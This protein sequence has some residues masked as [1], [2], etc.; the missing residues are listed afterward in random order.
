M[1]IPAAFIGPPRSKT[2]LRAWRKIFDKRA[3]QATIVETLRRLELVEIDQDDR[4]FWL[5][6]GDVHFLQLMQDDAPHINVESAYHLYAFSESLA[7]V[8]LYERQRQI[9]LEVL[10][11]P[12]VNLAL[13][14]EPS[15]GPPWSMDDQVTNQI[16]LRSMLQYADAFLCYEKRSFFWAQ[17]VIETSAD[18]RYWTIRLKHL[19]R[20][21]GVSDDALKT[22]DQQSS[23]QLLDSPASEKI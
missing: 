17:E 11:L 4:L 2:P 16:V 14:G 10:D 21:I 12:W 18:L 5:Q 8:G 7:D 20:G 9:L 23:A 1:L 13:L 22:L 6:Q 15:F 19:S 3:S